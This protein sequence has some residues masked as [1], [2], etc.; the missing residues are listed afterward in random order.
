MAKPQAIRLAIDRRWDELVRLVR[1]PEGRARAM[2]RDEYGHLALHGV[3][4]FGAPV[5]VVRA[6]LD[7]YPQG[8]QV[9]DY[10]S[11]S[12]PLHYAAYNKV[13]VGVVRALLDTYPQGAQAVDNIGCLPLHVAARN[14]TVEVVRALLDTYPQGAQMTNNHGR[15]PLHEAACHEALVEVIR[16]LLDAHPQGAQI[17]SNE[18]G[19]LPLHTAARFGA[20]LEVVR[21]LLDAHPQGAQ[22]ADNKGLFPLDLA[23]AV[24]DL[25]WRGPKVLVML[26]LAH[27]GHPPSR[28]W[29]PETGAALRGIDLDRLPE[30]RR[31]LVRALIDAHLSRVRTLLLALP[32]LGLPSAL[33]PLLVGAVYANDFLC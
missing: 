12:L 18:Y 11:S 29:T 19:W 26:A 15:L 30:S 22:A 17:A 9:T 25:W 31:P 21:A 2:E 24:E 7:A 20:P 4:A 32:R 14:Q 28:P 23:E 8:A 1:G 16:V 5:D 6:L 3:A 13:P 27:A 33:A 10:R